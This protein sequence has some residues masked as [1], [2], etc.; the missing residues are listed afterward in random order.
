MMKC[1]LVTSQSFQCP[2]S[3]LGKVRSH[4]AHLDLDIHPSTD[5]LPGDLCH[6]ALLTPASPPCQVVRR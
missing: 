2:T 1:F 5:R 6:L 4:E 3:L